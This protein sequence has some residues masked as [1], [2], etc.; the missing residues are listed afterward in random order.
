MFM[1]KQ[2]NAVAPAC[3]PVI[4]RL[5]IKSDKWKFVIGKIGKPLHPQDQK[6]TDTHQ[7]RARRG[8]GI[9]R[10]LPKFCG[11]TREEGVLGG[12]RSGGRGSPTAALP[13][14]LPGAVSEPRRHREGPVGVPRALAEPRR[15]RASAV[16]VPQ[17]ALLAARLCGRRRFV[18]GDRAQ[19]GGDLSIIDVLV[20]T[21]GDAALQKGRGEFETSAS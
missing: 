2:A 3:A 8:E 15:H 7:V 16:S 20:F 19:V 6:L 18:V 10:K 4:L 17:G 13:R 1:N 21:A 5:V 14:G 9:L 12:G 11:R